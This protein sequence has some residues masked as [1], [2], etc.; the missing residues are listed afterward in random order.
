MLELGKRGDRCPRAWM[1][2]APAR[3]K[4]FCCSVVAVLSDWVSFFPFAPR[5]FASLY[6]Y[7]ARKINGLTERN[8]YEEAQ[9]ILYRTN[10]FVTGPGLDTPFHMSRL[11]LPEY[12]ALIT[13]MDISIEMTMPYTA[14]P[15]LPGNWA[16]V[17]PAF[18][19]LFDSSFSHVRHLCLTL[20]L[21]PWRLSKVTVTD[22]SLDA[23][24]APWE[25]LA[26][27]RE[28]KQ[29]DLCVPQDWYE[30]LKTKA[31]AQGVWSLRVTEWGTCVSLPC[32]KA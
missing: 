32:H 27:S 14:P 6:N 3:S 18:L 21:K 31:T 22:E 2:W 9:P 26:I 11:L 23:F 30:R 7:R 17:Y 10:T 8:S 1:G 19:A 24:F 13:S 15:D 20:A 4:D 29:L 16:T 12:T 28:W 25:A 5:S